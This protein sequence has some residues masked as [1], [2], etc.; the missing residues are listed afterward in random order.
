MKNITY[1]FQRN[2]IWYFRKK[3]KAGVIFGKKKSFTYKISLKNVLSLLTYHKALLNNTI[4]PTF[5]KRYVDFR[6]NS[7][8]FINMISFKNSYSFFYL[9]KLINLNKY[10][11]IVITR[12]KLVSKIVT[13]LFVNMLIDVKII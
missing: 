13:V 8:D 1:C 11:N 7:L 5:R 3:I 12:V 10:Y 2:N 9:K 4:I 6:V